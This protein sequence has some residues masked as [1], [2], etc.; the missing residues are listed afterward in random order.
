MRTFI[1][2]LLE[3]KLA[4][5]VFGSVALFY[6]LFDA[7]LGR[8]LTI[9][10]QVIA[11]AVLF[12][13][14]PVLASIGR[15]IASPYR[16][17]ALAIGGATLCAITWMALIAIYFLITSGFT[18]P[19]GMAGV[20]RCGI[21]SIFMYVP[22]IWLASGGVWSQPTMVSDASNR[23]PRRHY[24]AVAMAIGWL[25]LIAAISAPEAT[26]SVFLFLI[27]PWGPMSTV[28]GPVTLVLCAVNVIRDSRSM[29]KWMRWLLV[30]IVI[31]LLL[32]FIH[33]YGLLFLMI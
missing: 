32:R 4:I 30:A 11:L 31:A 29:A 21:G 5:I 6:L 24:A 7:L 8:Q 28:L 13:A 19:Q 10:V 25:L 1:E 17:L 18:S 2:S 22:L 26:V 12:L 27:E 3:P 20:F 23:S 15:R 16:R 9:A 33:R 14:T